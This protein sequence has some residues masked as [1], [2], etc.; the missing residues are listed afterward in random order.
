MKCS[1]DWRPANGSF[2]KSP[3][4][5]NE[6]H[7]ECFTH[8]QKYYHCLYDHYYYNKLCCGFTSMPKKS[9][10]KKKRIKESQAK[11]KSEKNSQG[12]A[13]AAIS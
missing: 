11:N 3:K 5:K 13:S 8:G 7:F 10:Q 6:H 2:V 12:N 9:Q 4:N 1:S